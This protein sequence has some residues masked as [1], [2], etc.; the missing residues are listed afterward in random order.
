MRIM[1]MRDDCPYFLDL[2]RRF[3]CGLFQPGERHGRQTGAGTVLGLSTKDQCVGFVSDGQ[4]MKFTEFEAPI[5]YGAAMH[6]RTLAHEFPGKT[7]RG[8]SGF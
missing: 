3:Q 6:L 1:G 2:T 7:T 4:H 5:S 8:A